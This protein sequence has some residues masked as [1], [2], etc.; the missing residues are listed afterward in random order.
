MPGG[1]AQKRPLSP[2]AG[3]E[4]RPAVRQKPCADAAENTCLFC[5][6]SVEEDGVKLCECRCA[7]RGL[8]CCVPCLYKTGIGTL[9][10]KRTGGSL[11]RCTICKENF[12]DDVIREVVA[13]SMSIAEALPPDDQARIN[14]ELLNVD[15]LMQMKDLQAARKLIQTLSSRYTEC[16][17]AEHAST[18]L[19]EFKLGLWHLRQSN[20][21][22]AM[23]T[24]VSVDA[25]QT[26]PSAPDQVDW[27][28]NLLSTRGMLAVALSHMGLKSTGAAKHRYLDMAESTL[29]NVVRRLRSLVGPSDPRFVT[30]QSNFSTVLSLR[31]KALK[32]RMQKERFE[33]ATAATGYTVHLQGLLYGASDARTKNTAAR[34]S[35]M[36][37]R[38][39]AAHASL[40]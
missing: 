9:E 32:T 28:L 19:L 26:T 2:T 4:A 29:F 8:V 22:E 3:P 24:F 14:R 13:Y 10:M 40:R 23:R 7:C 31:H 25:K 15:T 35:I 33:V 18:V 27:L 6:S 17:G 1:S 20:F 36:Q 37:A 11:V 21:F 16:L 34:L 12:C 5:G 30:H 39:A 38:L